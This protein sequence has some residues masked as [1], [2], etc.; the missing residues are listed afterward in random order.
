MWQA[1][2]ATI[3]LGS[4]LLPSGERLAAGWSNLLE[5]GGKF[6]TVFRGKAAQGLP[7]VSIET[8]G[9]ELKTLAPAAK[10]V[11]IHVSAAEDLTLFDVS[12]KSS[13]KPNGLW[14]S[15]KLEWVPQGRPISPL[16]VVRGHAYHV[17]ST[18]ARMFDVANAD[19]LQSL[20]RRYGRTSEFP[21][22]L[23]GKLSIPDIELSK[24]RNAAEPQLYAYK[25]SEIDWGE[26]AKSFDGIRFSNYRGV[27]DSVLVP[28]WFDGLDLSSSVT[29]NNV[30]R[31][32]VT[33]LGKVPSLYDPRFQDK[34]SDIVSKAAEVQ[35]KI[36]G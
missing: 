30:G 23:E 13:F 7:E 34:L 28:R 8:T 9:S 5:V 36:L 25:N 3:A 29:W 4:K 26:M 10:P 11:D 32:K 35:S 18:G 20:I 14:A 31:V 16:D 12:P 15:D 6:P 19:G 17:D 1:A 33:P 22:R 2:E 21:S 24:M 27:K